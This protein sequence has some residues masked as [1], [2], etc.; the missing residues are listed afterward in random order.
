MLAT[1]P[2]GCKPHWPFVR[3]LRVPFF[4]ENNLPPHRNKL[5][6]SYIA[7][8]GAFFDRLRRKGSGLFGGGPERSD[9]T[10]LDF[11][12]QEIGREGCEPLKFLLFAQ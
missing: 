2:V 5:Y 12:L 1:R 4:A 10:S 11:E 8:P 6:R 7:N 3:R 9:R